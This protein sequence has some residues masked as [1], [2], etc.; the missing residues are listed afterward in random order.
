MT[1]ELTDF[2]LDVLILVRLKTLSNLTSVQRR[3]IVREGCNLNGTLSEFVVQFYHL[4]GGFNN[5]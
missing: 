5:N 2:F 4:F 1:P 3:I